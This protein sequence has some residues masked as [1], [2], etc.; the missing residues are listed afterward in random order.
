MPHIKNALIRFRIIDKMLRNKYR[1]FPSK[2]ELREACEE[3]LYGSI[4]GE[5]ICDSTIE[6]DLFNMKME[7]DAPIKYSKRER[8]YFYEDSDYSINDIPLT[9]DELNSIKYAVDTLQQFKDAPF[10]KEFGNAIDKIVDR[11]SVGSSENEINQ[12]IQFESATS[13]G[14]NEYLPLLL[15]AIQRKK[16]VWFLYTSYIKAEEKPRKVSPLYLKEYRNRW[17][18]ISYDGN[19]KDMRTYALDRIDSPKILEEEETFYPGD[20]DAE[21]YFKHSMGITSYKG[22]SNKITIKANTVASRYIKSQPIHES[23]EIKEEGKDFTLF[24]LTLLISEELIRTILSYGGEIE[25]VEPAEL[26]NVIQQRVSS[27]KNLYNLN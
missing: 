19:Q 23:Q 18:L 26:R 6:K 4:S 21:N 8:G 25:I 10:F 24:V 20:F 14:G 12:F 17:Y 15:E 22:K 16:Q 1:P 5:H 13:I 11:I 2:K 27:M 3:S 7:H 9:E